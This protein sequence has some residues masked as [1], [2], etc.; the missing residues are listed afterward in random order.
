LR[1]WALH[2]AGAAFVIVAMLGGLFWLTWLGLP[3]DRTVVA[4]QATIVSLAP[5]LGS[6]SSLPPYAIISLR[7]DD[8][9]WETIGRPLSCLP[10]LNPGDRV[11]LAGLRD[12]IG[13]VKWS[14][15][16]EPCL[17]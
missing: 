12:R 6:R 16:G 3:A 4:T 10:R 2:E 9:T 13:R 7:L 17:H 8:G 1:H 11:R 5:G 15:V 14:I